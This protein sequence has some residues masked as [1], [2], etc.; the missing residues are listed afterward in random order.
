MVGELKDKLSRKQQLNQELEEQYQTL[1]KELKK[2]K[3]E[4]K[5][6]SRTTETDKEI[7]HIPTTLRQSD[8]CEET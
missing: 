3:K 4:E 8:D 5:K 1:Q 7:V 2:K 6:K